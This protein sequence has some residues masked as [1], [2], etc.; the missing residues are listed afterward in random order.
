MAYII[1]NTSGLINT[2]LT[3]VGRRNISQGNFSISY[4]QIGD[5]EVSYNAVA[6]YNQTNNDIL[7]PAFNAQNDT[8]SPQSNKQNIKYPYYVQGGDGG[9]EYAMLTL[10]TGGRNYGSLFGVTA[11]E[12]AHSWF[13]HVLATNETKHEWMDEGFTSFISALASNEVLEQNK[14]FPL[15]GSYAGY[16]RLATSGVEMP[17]STN[18]NRYEHNFAY[19]STAYNKGAVF[20]GQL[21]YLVGKE[22]FFKILQTY[23]EEWKFKHPQPNDFRR[24]AERISGIQLQWYLTDW[25]QTTNKI[26]YAIA[27]LDS[28]EE[29]SL[30]RLERKELMPMPLEILVVSKNG[31]TDLHYIPI[32]LMRGEKENPYSMD[33]TVEKDWAW[34]NPKYEL[35]LKQKKEDIET[36]LIDPSGLMA[37]I[38][39]SNNYYVAPA[40]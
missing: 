21:I 25:T 1:K 28:H 8:G 19:E 39:K 37:D 14:E 4:F 16:F 38:D 15:E 22:T 32:S 24:I 33:W 17:Q 40:E 30:L 18:A 7:M 34:A 9:M 27:A 2:R 29:G 12:L 10:I 36:I 3:D 5:S 35:I 23:Y 13:Q 20:L 6:N 26:D 11:H 31:D